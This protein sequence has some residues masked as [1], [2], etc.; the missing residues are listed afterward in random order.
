MNEITIS[1]YSREK[2]KKLREKKLT[3]IAH[4]ID[5]VETRFVSSRLNKNN[6]N[7]ETDTDTES[8]VIQ[9]NW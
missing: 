5:A 7:I 2:K 1:I 4:L 9:P 8:I 3:F 6:N